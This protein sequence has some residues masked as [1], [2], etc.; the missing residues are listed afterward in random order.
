MTLEQEV[1]EYSNKIERSE[2]GLVEECFI[3]GANSI[4][5][6]KQIIEAKIEAMMIAYDNPRG[7]FY[8]IEELEQQL[9]TL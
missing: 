2:D 7:V 4:Y 6:K 3:A 8:R 5:V 9:K 1:Q